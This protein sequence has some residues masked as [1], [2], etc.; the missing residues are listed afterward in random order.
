MF[1]LS[2]KYLD[3]IPASIDWKNFKELCSVIV[4][5]YLPDFSKLC[6]L[7]KDDDEIK[8]F[9]YDPVKDISISIE[10][11][12]QEV[13]YFLF[14]I[15]KSI[16]NNTKQEKYPDLFTAWFYNQIRFL[17]KEIKIF[18]YD[19]KITSNNIDIN[20][21]DYNIKYFFMLLFNNDKIYNSCFDPIHKNIYMLKKYVDLPFDQVNKQDMMILERKITSIIRFIRYS[22][23]S[24]IES[25]I[26]KY[27]LDKCEDLWLIKL[28]QMKL[29]NTIDEYIN[30]IIFQDRN[31]LLNYLLIYLDNDFLEKNE[32][33]HFCCE[34]SKYSSVL[35]L[36]KKGMNVNKKSTKGITPLMISASLVDEKMVEILLNNHADPELE[37]DYG[38]IASEKI[39]NFDFANNLF[40]H[41]EEIR[42]NNKGA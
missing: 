6:F 36:L 7:E 33:L 9:L 26:I 29:I 27:M 16:I 21:N 34:H 20:K 35:S 31:D 24:E 18:F 3:E 22:H 5:L 4:S 40:N 41:M 14:D 28:H 37:D 11:F 25:I 32:C 1:L 30:D 17:N 42:K 15:Y 13:N 2:E 12:L 8:A 23:K 10:K 39:P 38:I 19:G